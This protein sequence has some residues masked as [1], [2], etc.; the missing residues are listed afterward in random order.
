MSVANASGRPASEGLSP[1]ALAATLAAFSAVGLA[2]YAAC[3]EAPF[4]SDDWGYLQHNPNLRLPLGAALRRVLIEPY[5]A[6]WSPLHHLLLLIEWR[7]FGP[8]PLPYH[9][10]NVALHAGGATVLAAAAVRGG[11]SRGAAFAAGALLLVHPAASEAVAWISQSKTL[12]CVL[13]ALL[14]LERWLAH[15]ERPGCARYAGML[16][17]GVLALLAKPAA[18][19]LPAALFCAALCRRADPRR[20]ALDLAPLAGA[21]A[22]T[23]SLALAAQA[24]AGGVAEWFGGSPLATAQ[25]LPWIVW[26]YVRL[27]FLPREL[28]VG[29]H[30]A[31]IRGWTDPALVG[32]LL[33]LLA[34]AA[35][36]VWLCRG[37]RER[38]L[39]PAWFG[40]ML[41]PVVQIVPMALLYADRYLHVA[42]PG[43]IW[44]AVQ[45]GD[46][47]ARARGRRAAKAVAGAALVAVGL[48]GGATLGRARVWADPE[49]LY[50]E[51]TRVFPHG[52]F[53]WT[54]VATVL[55][56]RGDL[57]GAAQAYRRSLALQRDDPQVRHLLA[58]VRLRQGDRGRALYD[59][60]EA[61]RLS[62]GHPERDRALISREVQLLRAQGA[63]PVP[64]P[65]D[66]PPGA[67]ARGAAQR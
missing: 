27:A 36:V 26:R 61:L 21:A 51:A 2:L 16:T 40:L 41:A 50:R 45:V 67:P 65:P 66:P 46:A 28:A 32:P 15:L 30:P 62:V 13:F 52:R 18:L 4:L 5:F 43:A 17:A 8:S 12:L 55:D 59:F 6:N 14:A 44:L 56:Q 1:R 25:I 23:F 60:E 37:R 63:L 19:P 20:A 39:G 7:L 64:D 57:E 58:R 38:W 48:L 35:T 47:T 33:A 9:V 10:V 42:L 53:G 3:L 24:V 34:A 22:V 31:P 29:A 11:F 49:A 54:G